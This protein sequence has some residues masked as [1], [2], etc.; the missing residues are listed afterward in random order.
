MKLD[1]Q[2]IILLHPG[3]TGGT[4]IE[5]TLRDLYIPDIKLIAKEANFDIM[6]GFDRKRKVYL[7][8]ADL[9]LYNH[10][11]IDYKQYKT[12]CTV[13][14]PY[15]RILSCY[16]YNG[17]AN[18]FTFHEFISNNLEHCM[19]GNT[20]LGY[21]TGHFA[22]QSLFTQN[23]NYHVNHIIR[24]E[25]FKEDCNKAGIDV[26]YHYSKTIGTKQYSNYMDAYNQKT[27]DIVYS[28]Y[29]EDFK[30]YDYKP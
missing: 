5:H 29:K 30:L 11:K 3:K 7:Q 19:N 14:R 12:F 6:F 23:D 15:E 24:L 22:P 8:H 17:K 13:R 16:F 21:S 18:N 25:N 2:K 9:Q 27:K 1:K 26:K 20:N 28:L 10:L 4:S